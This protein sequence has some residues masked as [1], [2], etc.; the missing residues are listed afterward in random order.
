MFEFQF[1]SM[2]LICLV[3]CRMAGTILLNPVFSR[4]N[5]DVRIKMTLVLCLTL[6]IYPTQSAAGLQGMADIEIIFA[7]ISELFV[8]AVLSYVFSVYYYMLFFAGDIMDTQFGLSMAKVF[9]P[10]SNTQ[11]SVSSNIL[12]I[13]FLLYFFLT[14]SHLLMIRIFASSYDIIPPGAQEIV[15]NLYGFA[16]TLFSSVFLLA[17]RLA[18]PF[19]AAEFVLEIALGILMKLIPQIHVFV[20]NIQLKILLGLLLL[21]AFAGPVTA[22]LDNYLVIMLKNSQ[23]VLRVMMGI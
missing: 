1:E 14:D 6:L 20:I 10:G 12:N 13:V 5:M 15:W 17:F 22:F 19:I 23:D 4:K 21:L 8:G 18:M 2:A 3:F 16:A 11:L 9:D 7:M